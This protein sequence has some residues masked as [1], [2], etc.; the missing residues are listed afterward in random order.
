MI[1]SLQSSSRQHPPPGGAV[2]SINTDR[3]DGR[4]IRRDV[5]SV[6]P[7]SV[8]VAARIAAAHHASDGF[9]QS[10]TAFRL[11]ASVGARSAEREF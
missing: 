6:L 9:Q 11:T 2:H 1:A 5:L 8:V 3:C 10:A 4:T 7:K